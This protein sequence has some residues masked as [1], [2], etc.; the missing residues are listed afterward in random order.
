MKWV[1]WR[2]ADYYVRGAGG[3]TVAAYNGGGLLFLNILAGGEVIGNLAG[4]GRRYFLKDH[5]GS[6]RTTVDRNGNVVGRDDYYPFGLAMPG[7]SSNSSNPNDDYKFTGHERDDEA[8]LTIDYM[9]AR[10]YDPVIARMMQV[11]PLSSGAPGIT[12]YRYAFNNPLRYIDP[13]G[14]FELDAATI[15]KYPRLAYYLKNNIQEITSNSRV[16]AGLAKFGQ[17]SAGA[18]SEA[19]K[20]RQG[21]KIVPRNLSSI[22]A[23]GAFTPNRGSN[24]IYIDEG[25]LQNL[26]KVLASGSEEALLLVASTILHEFTHYGDDQDGKDYPGEEGELFEIFTYGIDIDNLNDAKKVLK[27][28]KERQKKEAQKKS[29]SLNNLLN[30]FDNLEAGTY[31]WNGSDWVKEK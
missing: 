11:D 21:P 18:V 20:W 27:Q 5:V 30:D 14:R 17:L 22:G 12:P 1:G 7:R 29:K 3:Q 19:V 10:T 28:Y 25:I 15:K 16:M 31:T 4:D 8:G 6:V 2:N 26:E 23:N 13:D 9:G 24:V